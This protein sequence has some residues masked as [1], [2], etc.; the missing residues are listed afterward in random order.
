LKQRRSGITKLASG[1]IFAS[2]MLLS[3][4]RGAQDGNK[5][6]SLKKTDELAIG[7][8]IPAF[9]MEDSTDKSYNIR[10]I[11]PNV[12]Y[13]FLV[14]Y[15]TDCKDCGEVMPRVDRYFETN[16]QSFRQVLKIACTTS[17]DKSKWTSLIQE[18]KLGSWFNLRAV[19]KDLKYMDGLKDI[20]TPVFFLLDDKGTILLKDFNVDELN[21]ILQKSLL[22]RRLLK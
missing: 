21:A 19:K 10:N 3:F 12:S 4:Q 18:Y 11:C 13:T 15:G 22:N 8:I 16:K 9:E 7:A 17:K 20:S 14:F 6:K 1:L 5:A 2:F